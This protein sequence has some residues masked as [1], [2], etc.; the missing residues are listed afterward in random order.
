MYTCTLV[1]LQIEVYQCK[2]K[3][4]EREREAVPRVNSVEIEFHYSGHRRSL[5]LSLS[6]SRAPSTARRPNEK[7]E[8]SISFGIQH[9]NSRPQLYSY[10]ASHTATRNTHIRV[11]TFHFIFASF[12]PPLLY[13]YLYKSFFSFFSLSLSPEKDVY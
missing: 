11:D 4:R 7:E 13:I 5:S 2:Q 12:L 3:K 6:C 9:C 1:G 8:K 10:V